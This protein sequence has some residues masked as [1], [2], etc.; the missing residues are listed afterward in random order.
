MLEPVRGNNE[1]SHCGTINQHPLQWKCRCCIH[2]R[3]RLQKNLW[4]INTRIYRTIDSRL[5]WYNYCR[6]YL[7]HKFLQIGASFRGALYHNSDNSIQMGRVM[8]HGNCR[9]S[10]HVP[11]SLWYTK[12]GWPHNVKREWV[13][14]GGVGSVH[15]VTFDRKWGSRH[16]LSNAFRRERQLV[17][18][19]W[20]RFG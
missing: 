1:N 6:R 12:R 19:L 2:S 13:R 20:Y 17:V 9:S 8:G 10:I 15:A 7:N 16:R 14:S 5:H 4:V 11:S 18:L 3:Q